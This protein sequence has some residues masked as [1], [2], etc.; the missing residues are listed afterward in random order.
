[1]KRIIF[2]SV[3]AFIYLLLP[4]F[5][6]K[7]V[8]LPTKTP[9][10]N[11]SLNTFFTEKIYNDIFPMRNKFYT[12]ASFIQAI[13]E[14]SAIKI[15]VEKRDVWM[16]KITRTDLTTNKSTVVRQDAD[17][18]AAWAQ[19]KKYTSFTVNFSAFCTEKNAATNKKELAAFLAQIAHETRGGE[20][21][22]YND[23]LMFLHELNTKLTYVNPNNVYPP[24]TGK[25]YYGRGPMEISY[26]GNY[27]FA[28]DCIFGDKNKLLQNPDLVT[29]DAATAFKTAIYFWM[30]PQN[31]K[32]SA[33]DVMAGN[34]QPTEADKAAGRIAGFGMTTNLINGG[35]E[36]NKGNNNFD[37]NDRAG[38]YQVF[39]KK[40]QVSDPNCA[41]SCGKM[42]P[43]E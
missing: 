6:Y 42:Q 40:L 19:Q 2:L 11:S 27:G 24:A 9:P 33:H 15:K 18:N 17:W 20:D 26:N 43:Y 5:K 34:W 35:I 30:M 25:K 37:M 31:A 23:G 39:L 10:R 38:F 28:S 32:P 3:F 29:A 4:A 21:G 12:Y 7:P 22:K 14:L 8:I 1:M 16:Y 41:C 13:K 36:C